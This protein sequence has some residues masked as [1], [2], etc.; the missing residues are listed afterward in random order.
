MSEDIKALAIRWMEDNW[1]RRRA[2]VIDE[3]MAPDCT[4]RMEGLEITCCDDFRNARKELLTAFPDLRVD[5]EQA[6]TEGDTVA[7][8]WRAKG[9]HGG[10]AFGLRSTGR[11][12]EVVGS[13]WMKFANGRI[14]WGQDTWNQGALMAQLAA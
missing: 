8:R 2:E 10:D 9:S 7:L 12:F 4:G 14:V 11:G 13:T 1:N 6:V 3:L 5:V